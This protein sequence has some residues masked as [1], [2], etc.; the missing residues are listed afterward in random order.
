MLSVT[1]AIMATPMTTSRKVNP[2]LLRTIDIK[3]ERPALLAVR[4]IPFHRELDFVEPGDE[5]LVFGLFLQ[6]H[7]L[8][9]EFHAGVFALEFLDLF[10]LHLGFAG[11]D[12]RHAVLQHEP[13]FLG[14]GADDLGVDAVI[15]A[16]RHSDD[17]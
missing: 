17:A 3:R 16:L 14:L 13:G 6:R 15:D 9:A 2:A 12:L 4:G 5:L 11:L 7:A 8:L 10:A 1:S